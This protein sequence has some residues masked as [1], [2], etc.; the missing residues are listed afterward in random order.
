LT[1]RRFR[2]RPSFAWFR[3]WVDAVRFCTAGLCP[4]ARM[5]IR[6]LEKGCLLKKMGKV[7]SEQIHFRR[8]IIFKW[9]IFSFGIVFSLSEMLE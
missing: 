9:G 3:S 4:R 2:T 8:T 7:T 1:I 5:R 6:N